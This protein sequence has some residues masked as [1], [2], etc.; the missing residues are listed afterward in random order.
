M[1]QSHDLTRV[2]I[3]SQRYATGPFAFTVG[4]LLIAPIVAALN[5]AGTY[6][7]FLLLRL[8]VTGFAVYAH[9]LARC[10]GGLR[11]I[12]SGV[13]LIIAFPFVFIWGL[14]VAQWAMIDVAAAALVALS[15]LFLRT[16][17]L[18][19]LTTVP[20]WLQLFR[21]EMEAGKAD[22]VKR[23]AIPK[24]VARATARYRAET[25]N[26]RKPRTIHSQ[27]EPSN[28]SDWGRSED[29]DP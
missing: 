14:D 23:R 13:Y 24:A 16:E 12:W 7:P 17:P 5:L 26:R 27:H 15:M 10:A 9:G 8:W 4:I 28:L 21:Q 11:R 1:N 19:S 3:S 25:E 2:R 22:T 18:G 29:W 20:K 6:L